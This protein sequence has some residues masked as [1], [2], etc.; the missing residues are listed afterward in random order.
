MFR[1]AAL[2]LMQRCTST[3][4]SEKYTKFFRINVFCTQVHSQCMWCSV[5]VCNSFKTKIGNNK[6]IV[7]C[8]WNKKPNQ[9]ST[10]S[11]NTSVNNETK[12]FPF[13]ISINMG[14]QMG[15]LFHMFFF[16]LFSTYALIHF[17]DQYHESFS[18]MFL[19]DINS[20]L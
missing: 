5:Q 13:I 16:L 8:G 20:V 2:W 17:Q 4:C 18:H 9:L 15:H 19:R 3:V 11:I 10:K 1:L 7:I 6:R 14:H 12:P